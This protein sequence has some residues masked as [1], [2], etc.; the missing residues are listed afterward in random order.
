M[1][2]SVWISHVRRARDA[3]VA[4]H[5]GT[6]K[7]RDRAHGVHVH[8]KSKLEDLETENVKFKADA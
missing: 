5:D 1:A 4:S 8:L 3:R 7:R 6:T 2:A